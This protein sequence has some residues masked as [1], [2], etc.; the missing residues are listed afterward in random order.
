MVQDGQLGEIHAVEASCLDPQDKN[1]EYL[2]LS[3]GLTFVAQCIVAFYVTFSEQ[4]G[5]IFVD[6]GIHIVSTSPS[7]AIHH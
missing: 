4:S 3:C 6:A 5:G 1:G 7:H 2:I